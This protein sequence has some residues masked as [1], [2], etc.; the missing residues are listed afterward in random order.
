MS[1]FNLPHRT[2]LLHLWISRAGVFDSTNDFSVRYASGGQGSVHQRDA[3][4]LHLWAVFQRAPSGAQKV[5]AQAALSAEIAKRSKVDKDVRQAVRDL[6]SQPSVVATL[7][8]S[9]ISKPHRIDRLT[10]L[11][12]TLPPVLPGVCRCISPALRSDFPA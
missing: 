6:L 4:L 3:D 10:H 5:E 8:V 12:Q 11:Q 7:Q 1:A 9:S 2:F